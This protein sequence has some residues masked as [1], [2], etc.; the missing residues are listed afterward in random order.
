ME[1]K[2][3]DIPPESPPIFA[4]STMTPEK[5]R[6]LR[7]PKKVFKPMKQVDVNLQIKKSNEETKP[8]EGA[9]KGKEGKLFILYI[10]I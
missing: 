9:Q 7:K 4:E 2:Q 10:P 8:Q 6:L 5:T 3:P 1:P